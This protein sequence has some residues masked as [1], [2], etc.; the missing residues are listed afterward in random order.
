MSI[1]TSLTLSTALTALALTI[2][3]TKALAQRGDDTDRRRDWRS[4]RDRNDAWHRRDDI[5]VDIHRD[6]DYQRGKDIF[7]SRDPWGRPVHG[8][9]G[10]SDG[11]PGGHGYRGGRV[12]GALVLYEDPE[13]RGRALGVDG[14][15]QS[16]SRAGFNDR[17][18]SIDVRRGAW[19]VCVHRGF[20]G[21]CQVIDRD[22]PHLSILGLNDTITS[23]RPAGHGPGGY[24][25]GGYG[26][27]Y[28]AATLFAD[29]DFRGRSVPVNGAIA[30]LRVVRGND[31]A[32]S[33]A[34]RS[35]RWLV[36]TDPEFRGRCKVLDRP[37]RRLSEI[38]LNDTV[39]SIRPYS[40]HAGGYRRYGKR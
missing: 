35:G 21:R 16:L 33:I 11:R 40:G 12:S 37:V 9:A 29:P 15:V 6:R 28:G 18:S 5:F 30:H 14:P 26:G 38:G 17:V 3:P 20:S 32:S 34:I 23:I 8:Q 4:D 24:G 25:G 19:Q 39:S 10:Y 13:F 22:L 27:G 31:T 1:T 36:C 7:T 2:Q